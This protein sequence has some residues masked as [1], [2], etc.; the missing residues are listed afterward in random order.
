MQLYDDNPTLLGLDKQI[1]ESKQGEV[2][3]R[4]SPE[5]TEQ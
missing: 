4:P 2:F 3:F 1:D 5:P